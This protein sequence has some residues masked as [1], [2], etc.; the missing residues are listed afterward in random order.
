MQLFHQIMHKARGTVAAMAV[1]AAPIVWAL[2]AEADDLAVDP[3]RPPRAHLVLKKGPGSSLTA[4]CR[5]SLDRTKLIITV[6]N[7][8]NAASSRHTFNI[9]YFRTDGP[10]IN[11]ARWLPVINPDS[12]LSLHVPIPEYLVKNRFNFRI[13]QLR[14]R[15]SVDGGLCL[16]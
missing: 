2:P 14:H 1:A 6:L 3:A 12:R 10:A 4:L 13:S 5:R 11:R 9:S 8:G 16:R 15:T 7:D